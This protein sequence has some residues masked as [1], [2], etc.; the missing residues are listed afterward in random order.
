M[1][2]TL[3][4]VAMAALV[5]ASVKA[6]IDLGCGKNTTWESFLEHNKSIQDVCCPLSSLPFPYKINSVNIGALGWT[7]DP[8]I[9]ELEEISEELEELSKV[10]FEDE[11]CR[12]HVPARPVA[13]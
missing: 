12:F 5:W 3:W 2:K 10:L 8:V 7:K 13:G 11:E 4:L 9:K 1:L 6:R